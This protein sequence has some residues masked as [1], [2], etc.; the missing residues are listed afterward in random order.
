M[1]VRRKA[2]PPSEVR[3]I[4]NPSENLIGK[5]ER[6]GDEFDKEQSGYLT[7]RRVFCVMEQTIQLRPF[8]P[9]SVRVGEEADMADNLTTE[10]QE[11]VFSGLRDSVSRRLREV[12]ELKSEAMKDLIEELN[13][14]P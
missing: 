7:G 13:E 9:F 5:Q 10:G 8:H 14:N 12:L 4:V 2:K 1:A 6:R 3:E 11:A